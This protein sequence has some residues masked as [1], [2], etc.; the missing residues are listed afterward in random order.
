MPEKRGD[1]GEGNSATFKEWMRGEG[2][3]T[4]EQRVTREGHCLRR[5]RMR[6]RG[7]LPGKR[8]E[9]GNAEEERLMRGRGIG[10]RER[11]LPERRKV[12][13]GRLPEERDW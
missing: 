2:C 10:E 13:G 3:C 6:E 8:D 12:K 4:K 5:Q 1:S 9:E 7:C 11:G